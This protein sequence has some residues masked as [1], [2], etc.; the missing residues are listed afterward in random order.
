M[1]ER[2]KTMASLVFLRIP[3]EKPPFFLTS[4]AASRA[5]LLPFSVSTEM[6]LEP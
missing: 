5:C 4:S 2:G 6:S 3:I 1:R